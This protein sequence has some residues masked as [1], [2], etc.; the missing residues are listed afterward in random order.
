MISKIDGNRLVFF[1]MRFY[2]TPDPFILVT[3]S[4]PAALVKIIPGSFG[5]LINIQVPATYVIDGLVV[6]HEG[7]VRVL[8]GGVGGQDASES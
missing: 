2:S 3:F 1:I 8:Q 4:H 7:A 5:N 6:N